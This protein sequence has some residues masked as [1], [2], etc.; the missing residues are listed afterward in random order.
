MEILIDKMY[1]PCGGVNNAFS[2]VYKFNEKI[3]IYGNL[4]HNRL[5]MNKLKDNRNIDVVYSLEDISKY[6][7]VVI[8][9][10]GISLSDMDILKKK[11][12]Y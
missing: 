11:K 4:A 5:L 12:W 1:G 3:K 10:H 8:R 7:T 2:C 9:S 6:D